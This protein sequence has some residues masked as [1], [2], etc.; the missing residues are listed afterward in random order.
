MPLE[1]PGH[2]RNRLPDGQ[3]GTQRL[4]APPG[5][6]RMR[7]CAYPI[8]GEPESRG[9][10]VRQGRVISDVVRRLNRLEPYRPSPSAGCPYDG[11]PTYIVLLG[12]PRGGP[13]GVRVYAAGCRPVENRHLTRVLPRRGAGAALEE[14]LRALAGTR[15]ARSRSCRA[16][17]DRRVLARSS[18]AV[19]LLDRRRRVVGCVRVTGRRQVLARR[20][21]IG[22]LRLAGSQV[23]YTAQTK[24]SCTIFKRDLER[25]RPL[26]A[27][28][29]GFWPDGT[30][31]G[32]CSGHASVRIVLTPTGGIAWTSREDIRLP[33]PQPGGP[34]FGATRV[35]RCRAPCRQGSGPWVGG[36]GS[37][38][39][40]L[41]RGIDVDPRSLR[42]RDGR[43]SWT[44]GGRLRSAHLG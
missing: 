32:L 26:P 22:N 24:D 41:D 14:R 33:V 1:C 6:A 18:P 36:A 2:S 37:P 27:V 23:A 12:Y 30:E 11:R 17:D 5:A 4:L 25:Y 34:V 21:E 15:P 3:A 35:Y 43:F 7:V 16:A 20:A 44:R 40:I 31:V 38:D 8:V 39:A 28:D 9:R 29:V 42:L 10:L 13:V 19:L